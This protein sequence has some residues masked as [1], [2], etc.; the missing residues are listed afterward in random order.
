MHVDAIGASIDLGHAQEHEID[1]LR[2]QPRLANISAMQAPS[3]FILA[4]EAAW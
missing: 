2:G 1:Q 3:A 4:G